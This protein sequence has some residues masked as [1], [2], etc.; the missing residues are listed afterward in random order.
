MREMHGMISLS[1]DAL[2]VIKRY[3]LVLD[4]FYVTDLER[5][6]SWTLTDDVA[7]YVNADLQFLQEHDLITWLPHRTMP[8]QRVPQMHAYM[9]YVQSLSEGILDDVHAGSEDPTKSLAALNALND[10]IL[11]GMSARLGHDR[12]Q[13]VVPICKTELPNTVK[14]A[15]NMANAEIVIRV[16]LQAFPVPGEEC[17]WQDILDF[18]TESR[19]KQWN[20]RRFLHALATKSQTEAEIQDDIEWTISEYQ[21]AIE[22][23]HMK[24]SQ[25]FV[26]VFVISPL[27]IMEDLV[28]LNW[29]KIAR[30]I[31]RVKGRKVELLEAEMKAPGRACAYVVDARKQFGRNRQSS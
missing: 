2:S 15:T 3:A 23:H 25:S 20:F 9:A 17:A 16:A 10:L 7:S 18:K 5:E 8:M 14:T 28:K 11:R 26:D 4:R 30:G 6:L 12:A 21:K 31:L 1:P 13:D 22:I 24:A 19:D 27:E 29:S